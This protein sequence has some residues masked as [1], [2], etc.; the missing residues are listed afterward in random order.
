MGLGL[1]LGYLL[2]ALGIC[3]LIGALGALHKTRNDTGVA[4]K[5]KGNSA[6]KLPPLLR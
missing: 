4:L 2:L 1:E 6:V 3:N 5:I